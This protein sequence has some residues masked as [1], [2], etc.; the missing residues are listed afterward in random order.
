MNFIL[1]DWFSYGRK[2]LESPLNKIDQMKFSFEHLVITSAK[3]DTN[4]KLSHW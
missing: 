2:Y 1:P 4:G 3:I